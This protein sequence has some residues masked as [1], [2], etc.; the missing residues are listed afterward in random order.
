MCVSQ[1]S[2]I[3]SW[4]LAFAPPFVCL[5]VSLVMQQ[6]YTLN[7]EPQSAVFLKA[8]VVL[9]SAAEA[10]YKESKTNSE[11]DEE[12]Q[13]VLKAA[14]LQ[15]EQ[16]LLHAELEHQADNASNGIIEPKVMMDYRAGGDQPSRREHVARLQE[17]YTKQNI[18]VRYVMMSWL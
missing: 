8:K 3:H 5:F 12:A 16:A 11:M 15:R 18:D 17:L 7:G 9:R 13:R 2:S 4:L 14:K 6:A 10:K 1:S